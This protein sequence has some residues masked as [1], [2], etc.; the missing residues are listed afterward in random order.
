MGRTRT[1]LLLLLLAVVGVSMAYATGATEGGG[2]A[3]GMTA[4][5][6]KLSGKVNAY[7][8]NVPVDTLSFTYYAGQDSP[9]G[10]AFRT[11]VI[12][13]MLLDQFNVK[14]TKIVYDIDPTERLNLMLASNEYPEVINCLTDAQVEQWKS[15]G[16]AVN[17]T[18]YIEKY[19]PNLVK[20]AGAIMKRFVDPKGGT[21]KL[22]NLWGILTITDRAPEIRLDWWTEIGKPPIKTPDDYFNALKAMVAKHPTND[23]GEK[24]YAMSFIKNRGSYEQMNA[25]WGLKKNWKEDAGHGLTYFLNS[26]EGLEM[27]KYVNRFSR[28]GLLDPDSFVVTLEDWRIKIA[29]QRLAAHVGDWWIVLASVDFWP[30]QMPKYDTNYNRYTYVHVKAPG[31][32]ASTSNPKDASGYYRTIVTDKCT[33]PSKVLTWVNFE[34]SDI[35]IKLLG[36]GVPTNDVAKYISDENY[37]GWI[38]EGGKWRFDPVRKDL[39]LKN[40]LNYDKLTHLGGGEHYIAMYQGFTED[41]TGFW[42]DQNFNNDVAWKKEMNEEMRPSMFDFSA[43]Y[44]IALAPDNPLAVKWQRIQ[45]LVNTQWVE[46]VLAKT[47]AD[48]VAKYNALVKAA[49]DAGLKEVEKFYSDSYKATLNAWK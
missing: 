12:D 45:D 29:N 41:G 34:S 17:L 2:A 5:T 8:W 36:W 30:Q 3:A 42:Y 40:E 26:P 13:K 43:F 10:V 14:L 46:A 18:P 9:D 11:Q 47:E 37:G 27:T 48:C 31:L 15:L 20:R 44:T 23:K 25:L 32:T 22:P 35:G 38:Y 33:D 16:K 28:E 49:N 39:L 19:A 6:V 24:T 7:G 1:A 21:Y 4:S